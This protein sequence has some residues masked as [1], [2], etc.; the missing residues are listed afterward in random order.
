LATAPSLKA[1]WI[2]W[3][4]VVL[5]HRLLLWDGQPVEAVRFSWVWRN[6]INRSTN[7]WMTVLFFSSCA[8][9]YMN[10]VSDV[11]SALFGGVY[12]TWQVTR[13]RT[14]V[15]PIDFFP[16]SCGVRTAD[17]ISILFIFFVSGILSDFTM[18]T[19]NKA[20]CRDIVVQGGSRPLLI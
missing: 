1:R 19:K 14:F 13:R 11:D 7:Q 5:D 18:A 6:E 8:M 17:A 12:D 9:I 10:V 2:H 3:C 4:F 16:K 20:W 15:K